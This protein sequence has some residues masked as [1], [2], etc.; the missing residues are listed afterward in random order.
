M[1]D[2]DIIRILKS[3]TKLTDDEIIKLSNSKAWQEIYKAEAEE[4][5]RKEKLRKPE[6]CFTGFNF[7]EREKLETDATLKGLKV[8]TRVTTLLAYLVMGDMPGEKKIEQAEEQGVQILT[9]DEYEKLDTFT[10]KPKSI[11]KKTKKETTQED[12]YV[13]E[14]IGQTKK[15]IPLWVWFVVGIV[16]VFVIASL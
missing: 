13:D 15:S 5:E 2:P 4:R 6:I 10:K 7:E 8:R 3:K 11:S 12:E 14:S 16:I 9:I 1:P